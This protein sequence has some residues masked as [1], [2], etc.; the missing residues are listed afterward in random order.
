M[1]N[2]INTILENLY[3]DDKVN[4]NKVRMKRYPRIREFL[5][6]LDP[7]ISSYSEAL[8]R[9]KYNIERNY[10]IECGKPTYFKGLRHYLTTGKLYADYCSCKCRANSSQYK[11]TYKKSILQK[12]G[13]DNPMKASSV[14]DKGKATCKERYGVV[15]ASML[16]EYQDK[17]KETCYGIYGSY[18]PIQNPNVKEK[19]HN[20]CYQRYGSYSPLGNRK[21]HDK[22]VE[23]TYRKYGVSCVFNRVDLKEKLLSK[24][25]KEKRYATMKRHNTFNTSKPEEELYLYIKEKFPD[26]KRQYRDKERY[27]WRCD[28]YIP[29][30]DYFIELQGYYTHGKHAFDPTSKEDLRLIEEYR[31]KYGSECQA[32]TIWSIKDVEKRETAKKNK[33]NFKE[34]WTLEEGKEFIDELSK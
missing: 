1:F 10:C 24:E 15:R 5:L 25:T 33:L 28:F 14:I 2:R 20:T 7:W 16:R 13:V 3:V 26:V 34:V 4:A 18:T 12:Y 23:T 32:I 8:V 6:S 17:A 29:S 19:I 22:T 9:L 30:L 31:E 11:D 21:I 27:P